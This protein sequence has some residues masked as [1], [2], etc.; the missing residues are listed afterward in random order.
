VAR[1]FA[2]I[3]SDLQAEDE[4]EID[5][6]AS[7][8]EALRLIR[9]NYLSGDCGAFAVALHRLTGWPLVEI[10]PRRGYTIH[11]CARTLRGAL[12]DFSGYTSVP[13]LERRYGMKHLQARPMPPEDAW[14][15][16]ECEGNPRED[17]ALAAFVI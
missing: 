10:R 1:H 16:H 13:A 8:P 9:R 17:V 15:F 3:Y 14:C 4:P 12:V 5:W 7:E 6:A 11:V 2:L